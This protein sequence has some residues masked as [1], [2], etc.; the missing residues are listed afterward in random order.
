MDFP[1]VSVRFHR[2]Y[3]LDLFAKPSCCLTI[4]F[5]LILKKTPQINCNIGGV[6]IGLHEAM[7]NVHVHT[8]T[9]FGCRMH[10]TDCSVSYSLY[11][12]FDSFF[13]S[14]Y[15]RCVCITAFFAV[16]FNSESGLI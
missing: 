3:C 4:S 7:C 8:S 2:S 16:S 13:A 5:S 1:N 9:S 10:V 12:L 11:I 15:L 14:C 6:L